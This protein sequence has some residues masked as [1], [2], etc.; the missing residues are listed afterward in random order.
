MSFFLCPNYAL[1]ILLSFLGAQFT[2]TLQEAAQ[3]GSVR[4]YICGTTFLSTRNPLRNAYA[5]RS[6]GMGCLFVRKS[7]LLQ[8]GCLYRSCVRFMLMLLT[9]ETWL[10]LRRELKATQGDSFMSPRES[11]VPPATP[12]TLLCR[13]SSPITIGM[14]NS[15][16]YKYTYGL[17]LD[18]LIFPILYNIC[19]HYLKKLLLIGAVY[20]VGFTILMIRLFQ[21]IQ[22]PIILI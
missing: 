8:T 6:T 2:N 22:M 15:N 20:S 4:L 13:R 11:N 17:A 14:C 16:N 1:N 5:T 12:N 21:L 18:S 10:K 3:G 7:W 9:G 19:M